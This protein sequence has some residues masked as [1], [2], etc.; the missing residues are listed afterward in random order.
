M[1]VKAGRYMLEL[2]IVESLRQLEPHGG[3]GRPPEPR[4]LVRIGVSLGGSSLFADGTD[5]ACFD[6]EGYFFHGKKRSRCSEKFRRDQTVALLLNL[7]EGSPNA[8]TVSLFREGQRVSEPQKLPEEMRGKAL[9]PTLTYKN[10]TVHVN[11]GPV[12]RIPLPFSCRM[13]QDAA[14]ADVELAPQTS[15]SGPCEVVFPVGLPEQGF[16]DFVDAFLEQHRHVELSDRKLLDW[17]TRSGIWMRRS[18]PRSYSNDR[19]S[20]HTGIARMDDESARRVLEALGPAMKRDCVIAELRGNLLAGERKKALQRFGGPNFKK[21]AMVLIGEPSAEYKQKFQT[22][23][24]AEKSSKADAQKRKKAVEDERARL[25][26]EKKKRA[27]EAKKSREAAKNG[28]EEAVDE[29]E[30]EA[31]GAAEQ[32]D[33]A[34]TEE[35]KPVEL[36]E[37]EKQLWYRKRDTPDIS[38]NLLGKSYASFTLPTKEEGF[39]E[40]KYVWQP[41][42]DAEAYFRNWLLEQKRTQKAEDLEPSAWFKEEFDRWK[43]ALQEWKKKQHEFKDPV[44][45]KYA[46]KKKEDELKK[47]QQEEGAD[48]ADADQEETKAEPMD[49]TVADDD[50]PSVEDVADIGNGKPLFSDFVYEDWVLLSTC[51][52]LHL[53]IHSFRKDLDDPDRPG[54]REPHLPY[55]YEKYFKKSFS[56]KNFGFESLVDFLELIEDAVGIGSESGLLEAK[57]PVDT[58]H[59]QF[60]KMAEQGRRDR[61]RRVDAGDETAQLKFKRPTPPPPSYPPR[62]GDGKG[63]SG[64]GKDS[65]QGKDSSRYG[66]HRESQGGSHRDASSRYGSYSGDHSYGR[67]R[68]GSSYGSQKRSHDS[69][70]YPPP[71][72]AKSAYGG[73]SGRG[74][75]GGGSYGKGSS[76]GHGRD[77]YYRR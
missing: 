68:G 44:K 24:L 19:P 13:I 77:S 10:V 46:Q 26:K 51:F 59:A 7:D 21:V 31:M 38:E 60:M 50:V 72:Q 40:I 18:D 69:S 11:F 54:F 3:D 1:G 55:Y 22:F 53:L 63:R 43:K 62:D 5:S 35:D 48:A 32:E 4:N 20:M 52:E 9:Y 27:E 30:D 47:K 25:L 33:E 71:K 61:A 64:K 23:I 29:K 28:T 49:I 15:K 16:F 75:G 70:S 58:S 12:A 76:G 42:A 67:D 65:S 41:Q 17:A 36:T 73:S 57:L 34:K 39:D 45:R 14:S 66:N 2:K 6:S 56:L 37:E 74:G 8:H